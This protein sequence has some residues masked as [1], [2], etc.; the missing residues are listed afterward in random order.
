MIS[1]IQFFEQGNQSKFADLPM[2][3]PEQKTVR[4]EREA[5]HKSRVHFEGY[6]D[7]KWWDRDGKFSR[8]WG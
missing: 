7:R 2:H 3:R 6:A 1:C 8:S 4:D 5:G